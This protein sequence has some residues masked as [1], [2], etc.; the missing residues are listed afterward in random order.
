MRPPRA[1]K[2]KA[3][4]NLK[5]VSDAGERSEERK[6]SKRSIREKHTHDV[7]EH[8]LPTEA[9]LL[10]MPCAPSVTINGEETISPDDW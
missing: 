6:R 3:L 4:V 5:E 9:A 10:K 7:D 1:A 2:T 8:G